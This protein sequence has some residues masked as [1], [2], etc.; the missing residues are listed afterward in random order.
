MKLLLFQTIIVLS[1]QVETSKASGF[2][3]IA[4]KVFLV[5]SIE[6]VCISLH[7][8]TTGSPISISLFHPATEDVITRVQSI[9]E[10]S[11]SC[12]AITIPWTSEVE[13]RLR[14]Q[15]AESGESNLVVTSEKRITFSHQPLVTII[16]PDKPVYRP[17]DTVRFRILTLTHH[18]K[19]SKIQVERVWI[20]SP[21]GIV[22]EQWKGDSLEPRKGLIQIDFTLSEES[23]LGEWRIRVEYGSQFPVNERKITVKKYELPKFEVHIL[24][25][26]NILA[27]AD[28]IVFK[29]CAKYIYGAN[30]QGEVRAEF[31]M[32]GATNHNNSSKVVMSKMLDSRS[33]CTFFNISGGDLYL[34]DSQLQVDVVELTATVVERGS[35]LTEK[36]SRS[37]RIH[38]TA[39]Q[40]QFH[41]SQY[42]KPGLPYRGKLAAVPPDFP[43]VRAENLPIQICLRQEGEGAVQESDKVAVTVAPHRVSCWNYSTDINGQIQFTLPPLLNSSSALT[44]TAVSLQHK[45]KFFPGEHWNLRMVQPKAHQPLKA[46]FSS[47]HSYL[48]VSTVMPLACNKEYNFNVQYTIKSFSQP[49]P[50][51]TYMVESKGD[52]LQ[53]GSYR[54]KEESNILH[55]M[56][57]GFPPARSF[58]LPL[59]ITPNM[60]PESKFVVYYIRPDGEIVADSMVVLVDHCFPNKVSTRWS[61]YRIE[62]GSNVSLSI[63]AAP[64]SLCASNIKDSRFVG[65]DDGDQDL[66]RTL[67]NFIT[68]P[69]QDTSEYCMNGTGLTANL[70]PDWELRRRKRS[71]LIPIVDAKTAFDDLGVIIITDLKLETRPCHNVLNS[72]SEKQIGRNFAHT[73]YSRV[74]L[75]LQ[76]ENSLSSIMVDSPYFKSRDTFHLREYFPESWLWK[77]TPLDKSGETTLQTRAPHSIT[78]WRT[79]VACVHEEYGFGMNEMTDVLHTYQQIYLD[80]DMPRTIKRSEEVE[81]KVIIYNRH[82]H[83]L[84]VKISIT[85][86]SGL[87]VRISGSDIKCIDE[88]SVSHIGLFIKGLKIGKHNLTVSALVDTT[89]SSC[90]SAYSTLNMRIDSIKKSIKVELEGFQITKTLSALLYGKDHQSQHWNLSIPENIINGSAQAL[91]SITGNLLGPIS[92]NLENLIEMPVGCGEQ[93]MIRLAPAIQFIKYLDA[94]KPQG[95]THLRGKVIKYIQKGYQRQLLYRHEDGSYSAFGPDIDLEEGSIWLT[96]FV[97]KYLGQAR[98]LI[99]VD[100]T[101]LQQSL[102]WVVTK[103]LENGCFPAVGRIF[104]KDLMRG[105]VDEKGE[106]TITLTAFVVAAL[107]ESGL[108]LP[109]HIKNNAKFCLAAEQR[110]TDAYTLSLITYSFALMNDTLRTDQHLKRL[111]KLS[112]TADGLLWWETSELTKAS[113]VEVTS[114][115]ILTLLVVGG[116]D[117]YVKAFSAVRWLSTHRN[118]AGGFYTSQ[119][120][121][122]GLET[123]T[124]Y[125]IKFPQ[126]DDLTMVRVQS[127]DEK[128]NRKIS[129]DSN[130]RLI[131]QQIRITTVP[132]SIT[133]SLLGQGSVVIQVQLKYNLIENTESKDF[134]LNTTTL[135]LCE[136]EDKPCDRHKLKICVQFNSSTIASSDMTVVMVYF[137]TGFSVENT[138]V[139]KLTGVKRWELGTDESSLIMYLEEVTATPYCFNIT[140][141]RQYPSTDTFPGRI[142]VYDYYHPEN[143]QSVKYSFQ[144]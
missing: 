68:E 84:P 26:N 21:N 16:S 14:I 39:V 139:N 107:L 102:D 11:T 33:G 114:Y 92:E 53:M 35:Q 127:S 95:A 13:G 101:S 134:N 37:W 104:N 18:L 55:K 82:I 46:W 23:L 81:V 5:G 108:T 74:P 85:T 40:L 90:W 59:K 32:I 71:L 61:Q 70:P 87:Q 137:Q 133:M 67:K 86:S 126:N 20:E 143:T 106:P 2:V 99:L 83:R 121:M 22:L 79:T 100:E 10:N 1:L 130:N 60:S 78:G 19:I 69:L 24:Q 9:V 112:R 3:I 42:F 63:R 44:L 132:S 98:D 115:A 41:C 110:H 31:S 52:M 25:P 96:A 144:R 118:M 142:I 113:N 29:V 123:L 38:H 91:L 119:D 50:T 45:D 8:R 105:Y 94:V 27:D 75:T 125:A 43:A 76:M 57:V 56:A 66:W 97:L 77:I 12:V 124:K 136:N 117:N 4:P 36:A 109:K 51:F 111:L 17:G 116:A 48:D 7:N 122:T 135:T 34:S 49:T 30:V 93:N 15:I 65:D 64:N 138:S 47:S 6:N 128:I 131:S 129:I 73:E 62:P 103:Q 88:Y 80:L 54:P 72:T 120:T 89:D 141:V 28:F 58:K 140:V